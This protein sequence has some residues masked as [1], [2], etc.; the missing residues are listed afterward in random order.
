MGYL[1]EIYY[2]FWDLDLSRHYFSWNQ[3]YVSK[4]ADVE[5]LKNIIILMYKWKSFADGSWF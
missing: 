4:N 1:R 5:I 3:W 2:T